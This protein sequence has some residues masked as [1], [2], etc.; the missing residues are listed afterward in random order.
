[1]RMSFGFV[2]TQYLTAG[3]ARRLPRLT[4]ASIKLPLAQAQSLR[5]DHIR[6]ITLA[7]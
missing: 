5:S 2:V 4:H 3:L 7:S 6:E 1:V